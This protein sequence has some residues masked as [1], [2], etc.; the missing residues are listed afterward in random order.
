MKYEDFYKQTYLREDKPN[1]KNDLIA[2]KILL[3][4]SKKDLPY[5][6]IP[7][8]SESLLYNYFYLKNTEYE[9]E[10]TTLLNLHNFNYSMSIHNAIYYLLATDSERVDEIDPLK[11]PGMQEI[12]RDGA[13][14]ILQ[15]ILGEIEVYKASD[16]FSDS[17]SSH[18][19]AKELMGHCCERT[20]DFARENKDYQAVLAYMPNF[21]CGGNYHAYLEKDN[22]V[23]DI[24]S[25]ALYTSRE[26]ID[27]IFNGEE[28]IKLSYPQIEKKF[29]LIKRRIPRINNKQKLLTLTLYYDRKKYRR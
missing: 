20:Y 24:A 19:F 4:L 10:F 6:V 22:Q 29:K 25:N 21:F 1:R 3:E 27:K 12:N 16:L 8:Y 23:L 14:Y 5:P 17:N 18:I 9:K 7:D 26:S 2:K 15:T 28:I 11:W 13:R